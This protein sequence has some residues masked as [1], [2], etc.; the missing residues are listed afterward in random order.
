MSTYPQIAA[1]QRVT[2]GLLTSML[3]DEITKQ[4]DTDRLSTTTLALD[5]ELQ[6]PLAANAVYFV[7]FLLLAGGSTTGD[8]K[9][10]WQVPAGT[11]GLKAVIGPGTG[12]TANSAADNETMRVGVHGFATDIVYNAVRNGTTLLFRVREHAVVT[13]SGTAGTCG[14]LWAQNAVDATNATR[15]GAGSLMRAKRIG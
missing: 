2:A 11:S 1:G 4:A 8:L 13:T 6:Q 3:P 5:P 15:I 14:L 9:T 7:E 10:Q 12:A